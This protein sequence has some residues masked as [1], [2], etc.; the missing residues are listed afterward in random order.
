MPK[1]TLT[2]QLPEETQDFQDACKAQ[3]YVGVIDELDNFLRSKLKY[4]ELT[5]EQDMVYSE[6]REK[7]WAL[8]NEE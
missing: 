2:F 5:D 1:A 7:L 3:H 4:T 8:R 6:V